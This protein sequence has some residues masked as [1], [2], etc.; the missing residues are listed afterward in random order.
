[1]RKLLCA[2]L[3]LVMMMSVV[4]ITASAAEEPIKIIWWTYTP[5]DAPLDAAMVLEA[6]N[7]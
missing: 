3:A 2:L 5:A 1:M 6:A 7:K 4:S